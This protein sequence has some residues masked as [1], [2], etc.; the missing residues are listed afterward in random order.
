M[1][2]RVTSAP[3]A[4]VDLVS[5]KDHL[6]IDHNDHDDLIDAYVAA[7]TGHLDGPDGWLGRAL[8]VQTLEARLDAFP[9]GEILRLRYPPFVDVTS[10]KYDDE[11][12]VEQTLDP[13]NYDV[14][15][16]LGVQLAVD[17]EWPAARVRK[18]AVRVT[19]EA[20]YTE[21]PKA[22]RAAILLMVGDLYANRETVVNGT[23]SS[24]IQMSTSVEALLGPFRKWDV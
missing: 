17:C 10:I 6:G 2:V 5:A 14:F 4:V 9:C 19:Y 13:E 16:P 8:G 20:G 15:D 1:H 11:D 23:I 3:E 21:L 7:A 18:G 12:G 24:K 22:I